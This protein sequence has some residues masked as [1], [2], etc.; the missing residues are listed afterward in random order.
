M[1]YS[2][3]Q[4]KQL[5]TPVFIAIIMVIGFNSCDPDEVS[6][7]VPKNLEAYKSDLQKLID[8]EI[9]RVQNCV[10]GYNINDFRPAS[11][12]NFNKYT[13]DFLKVLLIA[14]SILK[15]PDVKI[16]EIALANQTLSAPGKL[17][18]NS[19][20]TAD[21][22]AL[23]DSIVSYALFNSSITVGSVSGNVLQDVK[24][25]SD[26]A[27]GFAATIRDQT[28]S[29][30]RQITVAIDTLIVAK[31]KLLKA[32]IPATIEAYVQRSAPYIAQQKALVEA[33]VEGYNIHEYIPA[34]RTNYLNSI[35]A[36]ETV[37]SK[38]GVTFQELSA[39]L[40]AMIN[41]GKAFIS[42]V[43]DRR[44]L[45]DSIVVAETLNAQTPVGNAIGQV[46]QSAKT[47]FNSAI[48][49]AR[50][51]RDRAISTDG[52]VKAGAVKLGEEI[53]KFKLAIK[54]N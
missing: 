6:V 21:R 11:S 33:S 46:P 48:N 7:V 54:T 51:T 29:V 10:V 20:W 22:R 50:T 53:K 37:V 28:T 26:L 27:L 23:N 1:K 16:E 8:I 9:V 40:T 13:A 31:E 45:N 38:A 15:K 44:R 14:D 39:A 49:T 24:S 36:A 47:T 52:A 12:A 43:S 30:D 42:N 35:L 18:K 34:L 3:I 17:F 5:I 32:I 41:P 25:D 4:L 19:L 2:I